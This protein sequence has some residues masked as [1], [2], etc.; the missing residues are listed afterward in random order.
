M[1]PLALMP[2]PCIQS[3]T[4]SWTLPTMSITPQFEVH[5]GDDPVGSGP[6][7]FVL[8]VVTPSPARPGSGVPAAAICHSAF[9]SRRL[10]ESAHACCAWNQEMN[11]AG[12]AS[13]LDTAYSGSV[14]LPLTGKV[15]G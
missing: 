2:G 4:H 7:V 3:A 8:Q 11:T 14:Q 13:G 1:T 9:V 6:G 10:P 5:A 12:L 15:A